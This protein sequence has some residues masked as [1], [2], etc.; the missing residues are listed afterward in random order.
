MLAPE[1]SAFRS[2]EGM[3]AVA[4]DYV[5][6]L[7]AHGIPALIRNLITRIETRQVGGRLVAMTVNRSEPTDTYVC[8]PHTAFVRYL[9]EEIPTLPVRAAHA[10]LR[11]LVSGFDRLLRAAR[12]DDIVHLNNWLLS[13]NLTGGLAVPQV[14][15]LTR[16]LAEEFPDSILAIR[17]LTEWANGELMRGLVA[18]GWHLIPSRQVWVI[19]DFARDW[20]GRRDTRRDHALAGST[21]L[22]RE[23][24]PEMSDT[25]AARISELYGLLYL[26]KYSRLNPDY[27]PGFIKLTHRIGMIRYIA[28]R[29]ADGTIHSVAGCFRLGDEVTT[30]IV[31]YDT[32]RPAEEGLYRLATWAIF[33]FARREALRLNLSSGAAGFKKNRGARPEIE[34]S[35][36]H[37]GHLSRPRRL[38]IGALRQALNGLAVPM[39]RRYQL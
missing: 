9:S 8:S 38:A 27:S 20:A 7:N 31:G 36:I 33:D 5:D 19:D 25:D 17:S 22:R 35:A 21:P 16:S 24:L 32:A 23:E 26:Q 3:N 39:M 30:P 4:S 18:G 12:V 15:Q 6:G 34:Y 10:P 37:V 11:L 2:I 1:P 29:D 13:T 28:F 14:P